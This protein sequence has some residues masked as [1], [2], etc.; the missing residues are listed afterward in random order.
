MTK[1]GLAVF[2]FDGTITTRDTFLDFLQFSF[3]KKKL[4]ITLL[5]YAVQGFFYAVGIY[6][7]Y[8]Y[9]ELIFSS[10]FK[11]KTPEYASSLG[12]KYAR[13]RIPDICYPKAL[14]CI[15]THRRN[16]YDLV[17]LTASP[18]IWIQHW[19]D[20]QGFEIIATQFEVKAGIYTGKILGKN[21]YGKEKVPRLTEKYKLSSYENTYAYGDSKSDLYF[22]KLMQHYA[23]K[24]FRA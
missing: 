23:Y 12:G 20:E 4:F 5:R 19:S 16:G 14:D 15:A 17:L 24:P 7:N 6:P 9:K 10:F 11:G 18:S 21:C 13:E 2:D 22:M 8:R 3:G 1:K